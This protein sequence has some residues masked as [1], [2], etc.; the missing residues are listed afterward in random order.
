[1]F[2]LNLFLNILLPFSKRKNKLATVHAILGFGFLSVLYSIL[3]VQDSN[4][5]RNKW[6]VILLSSNGL[7]KRLC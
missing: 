1:M 5:I 7:K 6:D 2:T 3:K 4:S